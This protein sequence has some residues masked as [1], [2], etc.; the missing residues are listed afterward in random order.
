MPSFE[1]GSWVSTYSLKSRYLAILATKVKDVQER[2]FGG[3]FSAG[4]ILTK[5][6]NEAIEP[7]AS[8]MIPKG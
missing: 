4:L 5:E 6:A 8:K 2:S 7:G 1:E 3:D